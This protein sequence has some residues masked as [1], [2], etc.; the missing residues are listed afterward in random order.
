V[1]SLADEVRGAEGVAAGVEGGGCAELAGWCSAR[2]FCWGRRNGVWTGGWEVE[3]EG[4]ARGGVEEG[5]MSGG[6]EWLVI[7]RWSCFEVLG[8]GSGWGIGYVPAWCCEGG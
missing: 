8:V 5:E 4:S 2:Y 1:P 6:M 7:G 3:A